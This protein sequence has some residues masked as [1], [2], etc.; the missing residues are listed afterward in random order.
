MPF[1]S[2]VWQPEHKAAK[3]DFPFALSTTTPD[4][5]EEEEEE[6]DEEELDGWV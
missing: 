1:S 6:E 5:D 2:S 4:E 3:S